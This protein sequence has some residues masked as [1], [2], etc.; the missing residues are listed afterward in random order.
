MSIVCASSGRRPSP[1]PVAEP[2]GK[3]PAR[4]TLPPES[5]AVGTR[6]ETPDASPGFALWQ[7]A[8]IWQRG[9]RAAL[10]EVGLTHAQFVLLVSAAWLQASAQATGEPVTQA[11]VSD[12]AKT[13][14]VMTSEVLRTLERKGLLR[15]LAHPNDARARQIVLT[16]AGKELARQAVA[17]VEGVD[18]A[19]FAAPGPELRML[20]RLICPASE[21][22]QRTG[23]AE[24]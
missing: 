18:Q 14:A 23:V 9:V 3:K 19:F 2:R 8:T 21:R 20:A 12:H 22:S 13:D 7:V 17:L 15:R 4:T 24:S 5:V 1:T 10:A 16:P 11:R 6:Y